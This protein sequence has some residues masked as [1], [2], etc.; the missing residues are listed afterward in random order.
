MKFPTPEAAETTRAFI[1]KAGGDATWDRL[2]EYLAKKS[3]GKEL[4]VINRSFDAPLEKMFEMMKM[5]KYR[6]TPLCRP[7]LKP[8]SHGWHWQKWAQTKPELP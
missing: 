5:K 4:F 8:C 2:A 3:S 6:V 7:G 1:K